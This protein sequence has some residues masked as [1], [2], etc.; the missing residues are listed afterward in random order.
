LKTAF[1]VN[2]TADADGDGDSDGA[3]FLA[4]QREL[5]G[6]AISGTFDALV[7]TD[8]NNT[9]GAAGLAFQVN[10]LPTSVQLQ[11]IAAPPAAAIPEPAT[12]AMAFIAALG[13]ARRRRR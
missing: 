1:G 9:M 6:G 4:W 12:L 3:D 10:Y 8:P 7:I 5:G 11:V 13:V 2:A